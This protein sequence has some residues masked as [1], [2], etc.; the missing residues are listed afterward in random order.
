MRKHGGGGG[1][2]RGPV[3]A[4]RLTLVGHRGAALGDHSGQ[5]EKR[6]RKGQPPSPVSREAVSRG[7]TSLLL[8][9]QEEKG[10]VMRRKK[11]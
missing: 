6:W 3:G 7:V 5:R 10:E 2:E 8:E 9:P 11:G 4:K 1:G